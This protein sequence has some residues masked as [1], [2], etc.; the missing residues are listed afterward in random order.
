MTMNSTIQP[1][2]GEGKPSKK[3]KEEQKKERRKEA[4]K[5]ESAINCDISLYAD[6]EK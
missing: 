3:I 2:V 1:K 6:N 4:K 5:W